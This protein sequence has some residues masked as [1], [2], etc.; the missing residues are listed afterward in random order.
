MMG[1]MS[2]PNNPHKLAAKYQKGTWI[3][4]TDSPNFKEFKL[5][6]DMLEITLKKNKIKKK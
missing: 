2:A 3:G 4:K 5:F 1:G 6:L